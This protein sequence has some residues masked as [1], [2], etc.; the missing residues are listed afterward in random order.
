MNAFLLLFKDDEAYSYVM[1]VYNSFGA[2]SRAHDLFTSHFE[3]ATIEEYNLSSG[4][5]IRSWLQERDVPNSTWQLQWE[6]DLT[7]FLGAHI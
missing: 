4:K 2:A 3:Y 7:S 6:E 5:E 1:G